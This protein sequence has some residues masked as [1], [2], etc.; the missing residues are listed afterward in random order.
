MWVLPDPAGAAALEAGVARVEL[1][2][3][4][5]LG[6]ALGGYGERMSKPAEGVHDRVFAKAL[7]ISDEEYRQ[8]GYEA[9]VSFYGPSL[10]AT[11]LGGVLEGVKALKPSAETVSR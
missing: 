4:E 9:S 3:P 8:G 2:P 7:V 11:I 10:G 6:A 5:E 1:T